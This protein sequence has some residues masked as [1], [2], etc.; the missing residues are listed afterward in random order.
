MSRRSVNPMEVKASNAETLRFCVEVSRPYARLLIPSWIFVTLGV[1]VDSVGTP[2]VFAKALERVTQLG[3]H[4][5]RKQHYTA[6]ERD[7]HLI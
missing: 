7:E 6:K 5:R 4:E 2:L 1:L 3:P